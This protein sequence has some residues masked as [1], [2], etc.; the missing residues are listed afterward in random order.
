[1]KSIGCSLFSYP[2][3]TLC[4]H[5]VHR[6]EQVPMP[7]LYLRALRRGTGQGG[8]GSMQGTYEKESHFLWSTFTEGYK[9]FQSLSGFKACLHFLYLLAPSI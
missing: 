8:R 5:H 9:W 3:Q 7:R 6:E 1:M 2:I 4:V